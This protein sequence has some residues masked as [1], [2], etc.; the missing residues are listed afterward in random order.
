M[1]EKII[2]TLSKYTNLDKS[3][4][5]RNTSLVFDLVLNSIDIFKI[6]LDFEEKFGIEFPEEDLVNLT[7]IGEIENYIKGLMA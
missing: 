2:D 5:N 7:T 3:E 4:L 1:L 6:I